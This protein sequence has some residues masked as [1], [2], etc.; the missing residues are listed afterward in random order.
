MTLSLLL[1][2]LAQCVENVAAKQYPGRGADYSE[3][4]ASDEYQHFRWLGGCERYGGWLHDGEHRG[5]LLHLGLGHLKLLGGGVVEVEGESL[6]VLQALLLVAFGAEYYALVVVDVAGVALLG[7]VVG[8]SCL[9]VDFLGIFH[10]LACLV[11][12]VADHIFL[13]AFGHSVGQHGRYH[14]ILHCHADADDRC[15]RRRF[16]ADS[17]CQGGGYAAF[18]GGESECIGLAEVVGVVAAAE[19]ASDSAY[20]ACGQRGDVAPPW[21]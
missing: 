13:K 1:A 18:V 4:Y 14:G 3:E 7:L 8:L 19:E 20:G 12:A 5:D 16:D 21:R 17:R 11:G 2:S 15:L 9:V 10:I 6:L